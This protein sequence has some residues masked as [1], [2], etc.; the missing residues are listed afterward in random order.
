MLDR[1]NDILR[2]N[3]EQLL[4][5]KQ[6]LYDIIK[7]LETDKE[8]LYEVIEDYQRK[9]PSPSSV[10]PVDKRLNTKSSLWKKIFKY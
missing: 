10:Q 1:E 3:T 4:K 7:K 5:D 6:I 9:L 2:K 8:K